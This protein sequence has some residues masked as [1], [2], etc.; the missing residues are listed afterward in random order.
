M[1]D[2]PRSWGARLRWPV[3]VLLAATAGLVAARVGVPSWRGAAAAPADGKLFLASA[4]SRT[5]E[6]R[7]SYPDADLHRPYGPLRSGDAGGGSPP[8]PLRELARLEAAGDVHGLAAAY[9]VRGN[10]EMAAPYLAKAGDSPDVASD[11]AVLA[12]DRKDYATALAL[13]EGAL[14]ARPGHAQALWNRGLVLRELDL[15]MLAA[16][17][18][19]AVAALGETG[20]AQEAKARAD[21][22][23]RRMDG[24]QEWRAA[25]A[26][27]ESLVL[28][29]ASVSEEQLRAR[30]GLFRMYLYEAIRAAPS[31]ERLKAL[32]PLAEV[33]DARL[34]G[35]ALREAIR[36]AEAR[37]FRRRGPLAARYLELYRTHTVT[38]GLD[39]FLEA[40]RRA[41]E[42]DLFMGAL[43]RE[44]R[45][46]S[47][48]AAFQEEA[49]RLGDPWFLLLAHYEQAREAISQGQL[50]QAE[51]VLLEAVALCR[52]QPL[53]YRCATIHS[54]LGELYRQLH[55]L[56]ESNSH[57]H[58]AREAFRNDGRSSE[59]RLLLQLGQNARL[60]EESALARAWLEEALARHPEDCNI[61][62]FVRSND[63]LALLN[64]LSVDE[65]RER[66]DEALSCKATLLLS[67]AKTLADLARLRPDPEQDRRLLEGLDE[68]RR[69]GGL[70]PGE[71]ALV[72]HIEG[73]L[74]VERDRPRG[75][76]LLRRAI[77]EARRLPSYN[78]DARKAYAES[79]TSLVFAAGRAGEYEPAL[80]LFG[81]ELG[82]AL[83][84]RCMLAATVD[85]ERTLIVSR[86]V[87]G[88]I[89]GYYDASRTKPLREDVEGLVP[90][91]LVE[92]LRAC[93]QVDVVARPPLHGRAG[94]L[95]AD[96]AWAYYV[97]RPPPGPPATGP[98]RH[99][100]VADVEAPAALGLPRLGAWE[101]TPGEDALVLAGAQ[102]TPTRVLEAMREAAEIEIHAHGLVNP[103]LSEASL[104]VL[105][106]ERGGRYALTVGEVQTQRLRGQP[107]V[108]LAACRAA[109]GAPWTHERFSLPVAFIDAGARTVLAATVD[110]PDA[111]AGPFF[112]AVRERIQRGQHA[113][114]ALRDVRM[115]WL[116]REPGSWARSVLVF[117]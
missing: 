109:H 111:E 25:V 110:V 41:G 17:S 68:R 101:A 8:A 112:R 88:V 42:R 100:V 105:S 46:A 67:G 47:H 63:A 77:A 11:K 108:I 38:G 27:G 70:S 96:V 99:L 60:Q 102:A 76:A 93:A 23:R 106:P 36:W 81:E 73:R 69:Q 20:W 28:G 115:E 3:L 29:T 50:L 26:L 18:F 34:G 16:Q 7:V 61:R 12:L 62:H 90:G 4:P 22:L 64:A 1:E 5:L 113:A 98:R 71:L 103:S 86:G 87:D 2:T 57:V 114:T 94:L 15:W 85:G 75:E 84:R 13:L 79:Y 66:M 89:Q 78:V 58:A 10:L 33:L 95:P 43:L 59:G 21:A 51:Q 53:D 56:P 24:L 72:T 80:T 97:L 35:S 116:R 55:R 32:W 30:P 48:F 37:D 45:V 107:L 6:A 104:L 39:V 14:H 83:P 92:S 74:Y 117:D 52:R 49:T 65:A 54:K 82:G 31:V 19:E 40:T 44:D 91:R 9:L